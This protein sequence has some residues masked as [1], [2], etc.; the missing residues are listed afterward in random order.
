MISAGIHPGVLD[1][2]GGWFNLPIPGTF[3]T[4][5]EVL[6]VLDAE[7]VSRSKSSTSSRVDEP[8]ARSKP[9][10]RSRSRSGASGSDDDNSDS[11][12]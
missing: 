2:K 4:G 5:T 10:G 9:E 12:R 6:V 11:S 3:P 8:P 1:K 7:T